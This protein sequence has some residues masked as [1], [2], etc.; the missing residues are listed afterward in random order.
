[1]VR[2]EF[3]LTIT[4]AAVVSSVVLKVPGYA[5][6]EGTQSTSAYNQ[7]KY[8][9][10]HNLPYA[11]QPTNLTRFM[12]PVPVEPFPANQTIDGT[13][14]SKACLQN[15]ASITMGSEDCL[16]VDVHSPKLPRKNLDESVK[17]GKLLP[18]IYW[19]HGGSFLSGSN[20]EY[21]P[22]KYMEEDVVLVQ[23]QYRLGPLG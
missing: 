21:K 23:V 5:T 1:M 2:L 8:F 9:S 20:L 22:Q 16:I 14:I 18:V 19:I 10:F 13:V 3:F 4:C 17:R 7:R 12:P 11:K 6:I 15:H